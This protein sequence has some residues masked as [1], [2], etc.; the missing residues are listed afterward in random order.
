MKSN[1]IIGICLIAIDEAHCVSQWGH[2]FRVTYR[3]L[4][5]K[6]R[7]VFIHIPF[8][9]LT[10]TATTQIRLDI[11]QSLGLKNAIIT[12]SG[13]DRFVWIIVKS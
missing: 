6:L 4:G 12:C 1:L 2:D 8:M 5:Y 10:A 7:Q 3:R 9:A 13:L 11:I